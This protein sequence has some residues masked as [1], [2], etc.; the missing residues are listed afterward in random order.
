MDFDISGDYIELDNLL[1]VLNIVS[2][3]SEAKELI[4]SAKI[5]VNGKIEIRVRRKLKAGDLVLVGKE[6]I[7]M[8]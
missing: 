3:G 2:C 4:K 1:K 8:M 5:M 7:K 6:E